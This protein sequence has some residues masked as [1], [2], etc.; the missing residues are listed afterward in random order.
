MKRFS[1]EC[2][3]AR[4][5]AADAIAMDVQGAGK[6]VNLRIDYISRTMLGNV[7]D[8]LIDLLEVA[9]YVYCADQRLRR[10]SDKLT[11]FGEDWRRSL[12]FS[13]P[14]RQ[15]NAWQDADVQDQLAKT[16]GF[17][18][19]DS[20]EFTFR[21]AEAPAQPKEL[22]FSD[23]IDTTFE[24]DQVALFSGGIDSFAGTAHAG[25]SRLGFR[26]FRT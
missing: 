8:L 5:S 12:H 17:L 3:V 24:H 16:L 19:D 23:L 13:I 4:P 10:G 20:Y 22:Y 18:S 9:S 6:N 1:I 25:P 15:L 26:C 11:N 21:Q 2:G 7:P 14:V